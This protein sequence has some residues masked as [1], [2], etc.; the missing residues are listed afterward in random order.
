MAAHLTSRFGRTNESINLEKYP[1]Q[2]KFFYQSSGTN[3]YVLEFGLREIAIRKS[4][5]I[6]VNIDEKHG[7]L[8]KSILCLYVCVFTNIVTHSICAK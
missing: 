2:C 4:C 3:E 5:N 1:T 8:G 6:Y 7:C